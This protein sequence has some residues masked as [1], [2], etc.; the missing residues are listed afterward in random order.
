M[1]D[2]EQEIKTKQE[3]ERLRFEESFYRLS[4]IVMGE[5]SLMT[6]MTD[7]QKSQ[8]A[9]KQ[10]LRFYGFPAKQA[11]EDVSGFEE[12]MRHYFEPFGIMKR[13]VELR[14]DWFLEGVC[15]MIAF[16]K[17]GQAVA[18]LPSPKG[19]YVFNHPVTAKK[20]K[21]DKKNAEMFHTAC[22]A[23]YKPLPAKP[24]T[25]KDL[26]KFMAGCINGKDITA[27]LLIT[28]FAT[29][30]GMF[31]PVINKL[32]FGYLVPNRL[33][34][35]LAFLFIVIVNLSISIALIQITKGFLVSR[36]QI[37]ISVFVESAFMQ[38]VLMLDAGFFKDFT[39]GDLSYRMDAIS[40]LTNTFINTFFLSGVSSLFSLVYLIQIAVISPSL[41]GVAALMAGVS[42]AITILSIAFG[43]KL[44][45]RKMKAGAALN[46]W[47]YAA[48]TGI[49]KIKLTGAEKRAFVKWSQK[50]SEVAA[51]EYDPPQIFKILP[52]LSSA[53]PLL[54]S[55][56]IYFTAT[57][58][59][60][61]SAD[62]MAFSA[63]Y[64]LLLGAVTSL[65]RV[66]KDFMTLKPTL[67][68]AKPILRAVP[69][70]N[71][72][73]RQVRKL[74]GEME[75]NNLTFRYGEK[76]PVVLNGIN[77][78]IRAGEY[79]AIVGQTGCGKSTLLRLLMGFETPDVGAIYYDGENMENIDVRSL[80]R[81]IGIVM[82]DGK[83]FSGSVLSNITISAPDMSEEQAWE[84]A[85]IAGIAED[86]RQMP[87]KMHTHVSE[88]D[89]GLS[90]GQIQRLMIARAIAPRPSILMLDEA[91][92]ALDNITQKQVSEA[93]GAL[94]ITRIVIAHRLSTIRQCDRIFMI[95]DG[96]IVEEGTFQE[97]LEKGGRFTDLLKRQMI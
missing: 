76:M 96:R 64:G 24:L 26:F 49:H 31:V 86:I 45:Q 21:A 60:V 3:Q 19:G 18:L 92:S 88:G 80:R 29:L 73:K 50:Y 53:V 7:A 39:A 37:K 35:N 22:Y 42:I 14:E 6:R 97:L 57:Q 74:K 68:L 55:M 1:K 65:S 61:A 38:R 30:L 72:A 62:Y 4:S 77:L 91:T 47:V 13:T 75:I 51:C 9:C 40:E 16:T 58:N 32:V 2:F 52:V 90:G 20:T 36:I 85:E 27:I 10:I 48:L 59:N 56:L 87:M 79:V 44:M 94:Q 89:K 25:L 69:E 70:T 78:R 8:N 81:N 41:A 67:E 82:Q 11:T 93:I 66:V 12:Q 23:F 83:L 95:E 17:N 63:S 54:A 43:V 5:E 33:A 84:V 28:L 46:G 34:E 71:D 15:P